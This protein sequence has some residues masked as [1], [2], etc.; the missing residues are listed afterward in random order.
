MGLIKKFV[1]FYE[2]RKIFRILLWTKKEKAKPKA[3]ASCADG[4]EK[5]PCLRTTLSRTVSGHCK[6]I[7]AQ[8]KIIEQNINVCGLV[9]ELTK[10]QIKNFYIIQNHWTEFNAELKKRKL[11]QNDANWTK[12]GITLK[13]EKKYLYLTAIPVANFVIPENFTHL[14]I[15]KG[16]YEIFTHKGKMENIKKTLFDIYKIILPKSD[17]KTEDQTKTG[18]IHFEKYDYRFK[19]NKPD[20]IIDIYLP[21]KTEK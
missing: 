15:P 13:I 5:F 10:S 2:V 12:Y 20:S 8:M 11:N 16:E 1:Y 18:F 7:L 4:N 19:W 9:T 6:K 21:I 3:S 17:L 14:E